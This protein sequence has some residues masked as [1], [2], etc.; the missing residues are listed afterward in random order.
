VFFHPEF[1]KQYIAVTYLTTSLLIH[2]L[3]KKGDGDAEFIKKKKPQS[4]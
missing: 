2:L 1:V 4:D 3:D